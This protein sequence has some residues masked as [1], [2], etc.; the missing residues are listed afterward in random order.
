MKP[1]AT[2][3]QPRGSASPRGARSPGSRDRE[4]TK[5]R[6]LAALGRLL[7]S[8]GSK[9]LGI[10]AIAREARIDKVLIY[11]YFGGL[12]ELYRVFAREG[13]TFPGLSELA[14]GRLPELS[15]LPPAE[16]ARLL[17][18]GF[19]RAIR[20]RPVT[21]EMMRWELQES[22]PLTDAIARE[23]ERQAQQW[24]NLAPE[25]PHADFAAVVSILAGAQVFLILRSKT[26]RMYNGIDLRSE[27]GWKRIEGAVAL[28]S[29]LFYQHAMI[30]QENGS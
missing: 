10:N 4:E 28:L 27:D 15:S 11:R 16:A 12:G 1:T 23:R 3:R 20:R 2:R 29:D 25:L 7:A 18:V 9:S 6:I 14:Q 17:L 30:S 24:L 26:V 13:D 22:N 5:K 19:G 8:K 21:R